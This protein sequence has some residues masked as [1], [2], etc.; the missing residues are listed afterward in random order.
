TTAGPWRTLR[1]STRRR[2]A[3]RRCS[4]SCPWSRTPTAAW[5]R[6]GSWRRSGD[7][8]M[9]EETPEEKRLREAL[10]RE[11][12]QAGAESDA[13]NP[14]EGLGAIKDKIARKRKG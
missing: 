2:C 1:P 10:E 7:A 9:S 6:R 5:A 12:A 4:T 14:A 8:S 13:K 11:A 3:A